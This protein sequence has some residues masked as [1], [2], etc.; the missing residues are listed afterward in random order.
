[1]SD[2]LRLRE[3]ALFGARWTSLALVARIA[4]QLAQLAILAR[5]LPPSDFGNM[6]VVFALIAFTQIFSDLGVSNA[7]IARGDVTASRRSSLYWLNI[8]ASAGMA[9]VLVAAGPWLA[10]FYGEPVLQPLLALAGVHL[11]INASWQQLRVFAEKELR[12]GP[13]AGIEITAAASGLAVS[14]AMAWADAGVYALMGGILAVS[15][16]GAVLG[17]ACLADGWRPRRRFRLD[18]VR[19]DLAF[20]A[21]VIGND[22]AN[23]LSSHLDVIIGARLLGAS[24]IGLYSVPKNLCLQIIGAINP[25]VTRVGLPLLAKAGDDA[26]LTKAIYLQVMRMTASANFPIFVALGLFAP[27]VVRLLFGPRWDAAIPLLQI[28]AGWALMRSTMNPVGILM[29]ALGRVD[30]AFKWNLSWLAIGV[31]AV[32]AGGLFGVQGLAVTLAAISL[33]AMFAGWYFLVWPLSRCGFQ[34]YFREIAV[35]LALSAVAGAA[36]YAAAAPFHGDVARLSGAL[37]AGAAAYLALSYF[38]NRNWLSTVLEALRI[39]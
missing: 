36:G 10:W 29:V 34:E 30:L 15:A 35:P 33:V 1:V 24:A 32:F 14:V 23:N 37:I 28:F 21:Y 2:A 4:M 20:G 16:T 7:I 9:L 25:V 6:A 26:P 13:L 18:E 12:F 19:G 27:E 8:L 17:W 22:L 3:Q 38:F 11:L 5:L 31:P 39:R